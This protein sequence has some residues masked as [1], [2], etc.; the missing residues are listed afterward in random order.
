[1]RIAGLLSFEEWCEI[2]RRVGLRA[3]ASMWWLGDWLVYGE[4][5]YGTRYRRA[6]AVTGLEYQTL[7]NYA[8][9]ARRFTV[10]RRRETLSFQHHAEVCSLPDVE[11]DA[12]LAS[13]QAAGW[14]RN[15]LR[16]RLRAA[17]SASA[18]V[19]A[20]SLRLAVGS[21]RASRWRDAAASSDCT[22]ATWAAS[23]LDEAADR[24]LNPGGGARW[25]D[26][27]CGV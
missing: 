20:A 11:Q 13:A 22:L 21:D 4:R 15:E 25:S 5:T 27:S 17:R 23:A 19:P 26:E 14:S 2:G 9:V 3:D 16:R 24:V 12:W 18:T 10:S 1:L 7:R 6:V 8:A